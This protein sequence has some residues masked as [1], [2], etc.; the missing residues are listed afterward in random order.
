MFAQDNCVG[1][2]NCY[3]G[4]QGSRKRE[5]EGERERE[6]GRKGREGGGVE[7]V[8]FSDFGFYLGVF[9]IIFRILGECS[10]L[11]MFRSLFFFFFFFF[12]DDWM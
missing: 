1:R 3:S 6:R 12:L 7:K 2:G 9:G 11:K 8:L 4:G 5:R 10:V